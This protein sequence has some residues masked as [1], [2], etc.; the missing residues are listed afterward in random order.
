MGVR[1]GGG[2]VRG[3][4]KSQIEEEGGGKRGG[5]GVWVIGWN[6]STHSGRAINYGEK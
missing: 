4:R 6:E 2:G 1:G 5:V 3:R